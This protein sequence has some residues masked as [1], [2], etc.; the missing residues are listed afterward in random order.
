MTTTLDPIDLEC[1][2]C[3]DDKTNPKKLFGRRRS[4]A[5]GDVRDPIAEELKDTDTS[6]LI[7]DKIPII[8]FFDN[9]D[10]TLRVMRRMRELSPTHSACI[11]NIKEYVFGG[12]LTTR[13]YVEPG[14]AFDTEE[15]IP[16]TEVEQT[17]IVDFIKGLNPDITFEELLN[18]SM[19]IYE[20][21]KTYG[22]AFL[23]IDAVKVAGNW[24]FY[25]E[26]VDAEKCRYYM[27]RPGEEKVIV[28]SAEWTSSYINKYPPEFVGVYPDWAERQSG[29][30]STII[31]VK[32]KVVG[33][34]WY[35]VPESFGSLYWQYMEVQQGQHGTSGYANDF[36]ARV[37]FEITAEP[38][39]DG[40]EDDFDEA[41]RQTFTNQADSYGNQPKR[42]IIRRR[43]PDDKEA[44][45]HEFKSN[46]DHEYHTAMSTVAEKQVIKSHNWHT[47]LMG[48]PSPGRLGQ[49]QEFKEVYKQYFNNVI[50][51]WQERCLRP[52]MQAFQICEQMR[53]G[54]KDVT[55]RLTIGLFNL[56]SEYLKSDTQDA[57]DKTK[58]D[59]NGNN[60][61]KGIEDGLNV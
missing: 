20:N 60:P 53:D 31:H 25:F 19:G 61:D 58:I 17:E 43:L 23:R 14:M 42:Y 28:I 7:Y 34:D 44:T 37:F 18:I 11:S 52:I 16:L 27:T 13:R 51:P 22:N 12:E 26:S 54:K 2:V 35:G 39:A 4:S 59:E 5:F 55:A 50:R 3:T 48:I 46:T 57:N 38:D 36:V 1:E 24:Y 45:V 6:K 30:I 49:N 10:A 40:D 41:V 56:Y 21:L 29:K 9:G 47:L 8:P 15:D 32:N 33:R